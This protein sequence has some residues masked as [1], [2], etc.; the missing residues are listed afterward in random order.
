MK[1]KTLIEL[2]ISKELVEQSTIQLP[3]MALRWFWRSHRWQFYT[4]V[5]PI[6]Y[7]QM[8]TNTDRDKEN[9]WIEEALAQGI[10]YT[11]Q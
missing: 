9:L 1:F 2:R 6:S 11:Y 7:S 3:T 8:Q 5:Y 10:I 4:L